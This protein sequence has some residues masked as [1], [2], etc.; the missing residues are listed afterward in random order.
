MDVFTT[1]TST[2]VSQVGGRHLTFNFTDAQKRLLNHPYGQLFILYAMFYI[3]TRSLLVSAI[4]IVLYL[5][6]I[7]VLLNE[8]HPMNILST[9]WLKSEGF[10]DKDAPSKSQLYKKHVSMLNE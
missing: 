7:N 9:K 1:S 6:L 3:S 2:L 5:I 8:K 10:I 4:L